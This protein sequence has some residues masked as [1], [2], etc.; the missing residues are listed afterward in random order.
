MPPVMREVYSSH[1]NKI[2]HDPKTNELWV[3]WDSGKTS[4]YSGV[5]A[6]L[7]DQVTNS[8]SVGSALRDQIKSGGYAHR[9]A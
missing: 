1:V 4:V 9:Y 3:E 5:S 6:E 7:A 8:W 2:G